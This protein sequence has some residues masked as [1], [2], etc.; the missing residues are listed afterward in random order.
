[1]LANPKPKTLKE[2]ILYLQDEPNLVIK[3]SFT[4][5]NIKFEKFVDGCFSFNE[6]KYNFCLH[7]GKSEIGISIGDKGFTAHK[8]SGNINFLFAGPT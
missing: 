1:M 6:D 3:T 5:K 4:K 2:L 8:D 7:R